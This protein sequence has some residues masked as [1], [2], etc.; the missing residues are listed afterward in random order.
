M[1]RG[2]TA[3][4]T[5]TPTGNASAVMPVVSSPQSMSTPAI[6][7][8]D[9][10]NA[11]Y[12]NSASLCTAFLEKSHRQVQCPFILSQLRQRFAAQ[13]EKRFLKMLPPRPHKSIDTSRKPCLL[14]KRNKFLHRKRAYSPRNLNLNYPRANRQKHWGE[15]GPFEKRR[16]QKHFSSSSQSVRRCRELGTWATPGSTRLRMRWWTLNLSLLETNPK[17]FYPEQQF[18]RLQVPSELPVKSRSSL[19]LL[20]NGRRP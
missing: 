17:L 4:S 8:I 14:E 10:N 12:V 15:G 7:S 3:T 11:T 9:R 18:T 13:H 16:N 2:S 20:W 1:K 5:A 19:I 6:P